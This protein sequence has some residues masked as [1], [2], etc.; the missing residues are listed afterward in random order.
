MRI[1]NIPS[2]GNDLL[3]GDDVLEVGFGPVQRHLL[4][5][6]GCLAGVLEVNPAKI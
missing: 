4:D 3:L 5:G 2:K 1:E 6:L